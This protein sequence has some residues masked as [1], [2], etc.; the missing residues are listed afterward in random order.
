MIRRAL[1]G[2]ALLLQFVDGAVAQVP[3]HAVDAAAHALARYDA[4][5]VELLADLVRFRTFHT[6]GTANVENAEFREFADYIERRTQQLGLEFADY[7]AVL[8]VSLGDADGRLGVVTHGDVQPADPSKWRRSPFELDRESEP[9]RLI[10]RGT[11]DDKAAIATALYAMKTLRDLE[12]PL[13]RRIE[14]IISLTEESDWAPFLEWLARHPPPEM[15]IG[16]DASY[17]IVVAEKGF[18]AVSVTFSDAA[19]APDGN[20]VVQAYG[21]GAFLSQVP[22]D[23][24][25]VISGASSALIED[26]RSR[27]DQDRSGTVYTVDENAEALTV[28]VKGKAAHSS[29]PQNGLNA[30]AHAAALLEAQSL[31]G[32][33]A[34]RAVDFVNSLIGTGLYGERLG[35]AAYSHPF[36]GPLTVNLST[37]ET[38][39]AGAKLGINLRAPAGKT[40]AE[41]EV[42]VREA[43]SRWAATRDL[44]MP[45]VDV[46]LDE[47]YLPE[48]PPQIEPLLTVFRHYTGIEDAEPISIGGSTNARLLPNAVNFGPAMPGVPYTAHSEHEYITREQMS[49]NLQMY[50]AMLAWLAA[51]DLR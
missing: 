15:N 30:L 36:M 50:T 42:D 21:G 26:I 7:G 46:Q 4:A 8:V 40:T 35:N 47:A 27:A 2:A 25:L 32:T 18:G 41:L 28:R 29:D 45:V 33:A 24:T 6:A 37:A 48:A 3:A 11:E 14:L 1:L 10:G 31:L 17:P 16:I 39:R 49:L 20:P 9:G 12:L 38:T 23:A 13:T 22:E 51:D 43:I 19:D 34:G 5:Q 44:P